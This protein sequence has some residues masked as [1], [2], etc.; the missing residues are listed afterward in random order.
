MLMITIGKFVLESLTV[1]MYKNPMIVYREYIQNST[2]A[3]DNA[4]SEGILGFDENRIDVRIKDNNVKINDNGTGIQSSKIYSMLMDI[5]QSQKEFNRNRGFRGIGR[6]GGLSYC[7]KLTF[8]TSAKGELTKSILTFDCIKLKKLLSPGMYDDYDVVKVL[9]AISELRTESEDKDEHYFTVMLNNIDSEHEDLYAFDKVKSF[10]SQ[11]APVP[12]RATKFIFS[13][14]LKKYFNDNNIPKEEYKVFLDNNQIFKPYK[15]RFQAGRGN[16]TE[17][18]EIKDITFIN[19]A[20]LKY[21]MWYSENDYLGQIQNKEMRGIRIR[22]GNILIG[23]ENSMSLMFSGTNT[24]FNGWLQGEIH[25]FDNKLIPN[26]RRDDF[27]K[28]EYYKKLVE[29]LKKHGKKFEEMCREHSKVRSEV[30]KMQKAQAVLED[31]EAKEKIGLSSKAEKEKLAEEIEKSTEK[32][33]AIKPK[34]TTGMEKKR[35]LLKKLK[36]KEEAIKKSDDYL[37]TL[38]V[39][40]SRKE[41]KLIYK[42]FDVIFK[43]LDKKQANDLIDT[44]INSLMDKK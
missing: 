4:V 6:L 25:V 12:F 16:S 29:D 21:I 41:K 23:D 19:N 8:I 13:T 27:E 17:S 40:Y 44:I 35:V 31:I 18:V 11:T 36:E 22:K 28:N 24:R 2:D 42:I 39:G 3:I 26:A 15:G 1:G 34:T 7:S 43:S 30:K 14:K 32:L 37:S 33:T 9:E 38:L 5:G 10:L 20:S